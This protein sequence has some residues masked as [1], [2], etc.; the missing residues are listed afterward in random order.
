[1]W[2]MKVDPNFKKNETSSI[3]IY[4]YKDISIQRVIGILGHVTT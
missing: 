3:Y 4:I 2:S 1:M